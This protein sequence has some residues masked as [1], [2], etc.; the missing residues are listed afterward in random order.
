MFGLRLRNRL[1]NTKQFL[2]MKKTLLALIAIVSLS[3]NLSA[4]DYGPLEWDIARFGVVVPSGDDLGGGIALGSELR[5]NLNNR[6]STGLRVEFAFYGEGD[7]SNADISA[8]GSYA[9][10][11]DY[12][13]SETSN[14]RPFVGVGVGLFTG[15]EITTKVNGQ[16]EVTGGDSNFGIVP[17]IGYELGILRLSAEY[18]K[19]FADDATDY[20]GVHLA[21]TIGGRR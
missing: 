17:R 12:Y 1:F 4:Q 5:F 11:A 15:A 20:L 6:L 3:F 19:I 13:L 21:L 14:F 18:N 7:N 16:D 10:M 2:I 9:L 8:A